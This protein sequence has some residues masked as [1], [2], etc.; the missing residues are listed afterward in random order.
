MI[1]L[2]QAVRQGEELPAGV[3]AVMSRHSLTV[4]GAFRG[5]LWQF[6]CSRLNTVGLL[7]VFPA[8]R[9]VVI[10][11]RFL[12]EDMARFSNAQDAGTI[13]AQTGLLRTVFVRRFDI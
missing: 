11:F 4:S 2:Q 12:L 3:N 8:N 10:D 1:C 6:E 5:A 13:S 9:S 7:T